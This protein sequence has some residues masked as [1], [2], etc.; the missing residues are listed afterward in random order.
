[1]S[2][3]LPGE[4]LHNPVGAAESLRRL[5]PNEMVQWETHLRDEPEEARQAALPW[6]KGEKHHK[7]FLGETRSKMKN[8]M[9]STA[10]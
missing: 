5:T 7:H 8:K 6:K 10:S 1:M 2:R 9:A 4:A 3:H